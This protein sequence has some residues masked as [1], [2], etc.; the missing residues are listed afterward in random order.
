MG[1]AI[2][3]G[4]G[5]EDGVQLSLAQFIRFMEEVDAQVP[6]CQGGEAAGVGGGQQD[7]MSR[8]AGAATLGDDVAAAQ[9]TPGR[10][11]LSK[12]SSSAKVAP[13]PEPLAD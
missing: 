5:D 3:W 4:A 7:A 6:M 11:M 10:P 1:G 13:G 2:G 12:P 9:A 8:T